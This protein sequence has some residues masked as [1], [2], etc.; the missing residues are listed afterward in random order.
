VAIGVRYQARVAAAAHRF[1][2][3]ALLFGAGGLA[4]RAAELDNPPRD[5]RE[6]VELDDGTLVRLREQWA[7]T[8]AALAELAG[9]PVR[10]FT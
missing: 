2:N 1:R 3:T 8:R 5:D 10:S 7:S 4:A 6:P 9:N